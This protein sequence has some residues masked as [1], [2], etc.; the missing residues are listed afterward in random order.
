MED[1]VIITSIKH[2]V[3]TAQM[4]VHGLRPG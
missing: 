2:A 3:W 1:S 4:S